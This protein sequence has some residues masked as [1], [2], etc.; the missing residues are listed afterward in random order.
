MSFRYKEIIHILTLQQLLK[1]THFTKCLYNPLSTLPMANSVLHF[2]QQTSSLLK[3]QINPELMATGGDGFFHTSLANFLKDR[4]FIPLAPGQ[5]S[6]PKEI[7]G[8]DKQS[9]Q[10]QDK[11]KK[12]LFS[13]HLDSR[14]CLLGDFLQSS[15]PIQ[16]CLSK[17]H[18]YFSNSSSAKIIEG[19]TGQA[20]GTIQHILVLSYFLSTF[21]LFSTFFS[22]ISR[23]FSKNN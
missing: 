7:F 11:A 18:I 16:V 14:I 23:N 12:K 15:P 9:D 3:L 6:F 19:R 22:F 8:T 5:S 21:L 20:F 17:P 1:S 2:Y 4:S 13:H 10:Y